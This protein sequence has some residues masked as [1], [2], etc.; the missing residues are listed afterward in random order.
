MRRHP[1]AICWSIFKHFLNGKGH[2]YKT[3]EKTLSDY[4]LIYSDL[5]DFW[6]SKLKDPFYSLIYERLTEDQEAQSKL[7]LEYC[8]LE[9]EEQCIDFHKSE[10]VVRTFSNDQVRKKMYSGSSEAWKKYSDHFS[11]LLDRL[12]KENEAHE[13]QLS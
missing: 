4:F 13:A 6:K 12:A 9:W 11:I 10:R 3:T 1:M 2:A 7:L 8:N 5:I